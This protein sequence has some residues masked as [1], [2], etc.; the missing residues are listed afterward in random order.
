[1]RLYR[2]KTPCFP[3]LSKFLSDRKSVKPFQSRLHIHATRLTFRGVAFHVFSLNPPH[4]SQHL[5]PLMLA[6]RLTPGGAIL[7]VRVSAMLGPNLSQTTQGKPLG[8]SLPPMF[9]N[10]GITYIPRQTEHPPREECTSLS[11]IW[12]EIRLRPQLTGASLT[13]V[14]SI[15]GF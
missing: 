14:I 10:R 1:M 4:A 5:L 6:Y 2:G 13:H 11:Y 12:I 7:A 8:V 15:C 3:A 9:L